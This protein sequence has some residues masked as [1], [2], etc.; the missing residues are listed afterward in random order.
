MNPDI[1]P[2]GLT[3]ALFTLAAAQGLST[4]EAAVTN[5]DRRPVPLARSLFGVLVLVPAA[6][7]LIGLLLQPAPKVALGMAILAASP[8]V[9][10]WLRP[11]PQAGATREHYTSLHMLLAFLSLL[12]VPATLVL[13]SRALGSEAVIN[14]NSVLRQVWM[15]VLAPFGVGLLI[16]TWL[17]ELAERVCR[18]LARIGGSLMLVILIVILA[19]TSPTLLEVDGRS[20]LALFLM[21]AA[22]YAIGAAVAP[23]PPQTKKILALEN[24]I[25]HPGLAI[26]IAGAGIP[27]AGPLALLIPYMLA[28]AAVDIFSRHLSS[29]DLALPPRPLGPAPG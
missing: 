2:A 9:P 7:L 15:T 17:P 13:L 16:R 20:Y 27:E 14:L 11:V 19:A 6:A 8:A 25:R 24:A 10:L 28:V 1:Y 5:L 29:R 18:R 22:A 12:T 26:L 23:G 3:I 4:D 21:A